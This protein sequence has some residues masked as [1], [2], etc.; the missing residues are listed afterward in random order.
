MTAFPARTS[1]TTATPATT[2]AADRSTAATTTGPA[3]PAGSSATAG[4]GG[5]GEDLD[6]SHPRWNREQVFSRILETLMTTYRCR[7]SWHA[8]Q[9]QSRDGNSDQGLVGMFVNDHDI[10]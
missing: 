2:G 6:L 5:P 8:K 3:G 1:P 7:H 4:S 10:N 9:H